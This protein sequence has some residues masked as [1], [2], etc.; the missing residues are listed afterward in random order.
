[1]WFARRNHRRPAYAA[2]R[3]IILAVS[4]LAIV[5]VC[6]A[7]YQYSTGV[8]V[9]Q[10]V[11]A[12]PAVVPEPSPAPPPK[13]N[14]SASSVAVGKMANLGAGKRPVL[15]WYE[16]GSNVA[17]VEAEVDAWEPTGEN[18]DE[19][20]LTKPE[21]RLR[22]PN[23]QF[24]R[25]AADEGWVHLVKRNADALEARS[26]RFSGD[27]T[28]E[29]DRLSA[30]ER[31][32]LPEDERDAPGPDRL[33][34]IMFPDEVT[35]DLE[36]ARVETDGAFSIRM[37]EGELHGVGL[38]VRYNSV[39]RRLE[40]FEISGGGE[41]N[42][43][44]PS[45]FLD[46]AMP[47]SGESD[48]TETDA[49][50]QTAGED[51]AESPAD[52]AQVPPDVDDGIPLFV[53]KDES[54]NV[55]VIQPYLFHVDGHVQMRQLTDGEATSRLSADTIEALFDF[56][57]REREAA[58]L[59]QS[60]LTDSPEE[61][62]ASVE[63]PTGPSERI[64]FQWDGVFTIE[65]TDLPTDAGS[66][67][68]NRLHL[69][70]FGDAVEFVNQQGSVYCQ[71][72]EFE[73]ESDKIRIVG[74]RERPL[75]I[76]SQQCSEL[77]GVEVLIDRSAGMAR[78]TGPARLADDGGATKT[79]GDG[80]GHPSFA[81]GG[82]DVR[83][84]ETTDLILRTKTED[85]VDPVTRNVRRVETEY[86]AEAT[87]IGN[88][89]MKRGDDLIAASMIHAEFDPPTR[90]GAFGERI[91]SL[92]ASG[93]VIMI[94]GGD[95][96]SCE[97]LEAT[98]SPDPSGRMVPRR[99]IAE[100]DVMITQDDRTITARDRLELVMVPI[101]K[102]KPP[103]VL[104]TARREAVARGVDPDSVDWDKFRREYEADVDYTM[105]LQTL[106]ATGEVTAFDPAGGLDLTAE[107]LSCTFTEGRDIAT[108]H[109]VGPDG[110]PAHV[111]WGEFVIN[112]HEIHVD[113]RDERV[114]VPGPGDVRLATR[115]GLDGS[116]SE[117]PQI[118]TIEWSDEMAIRGDS[119]AARFL[120][121]VHATTTRNVS[122]AGSWFDRL[123]KQEPPDTIE[124][125]V[126]DA[127]ELVVEFVDVEPV[128]SADVGV[129]WWV[130]GPL[131]ER[132]AGPAQSPMSGRKF[133]KEPSYVVATRDV[134]GVFANMSPDSGR[135]VNRM[136]LASSKVTV[137]LRAQLVTVPAKGNM[138][139]ED[140]RIPTS[141]PDSSDEVR[142]F[143][144][145]GRTGNMPS[146]TLIMWDDS[147]TYHAERRRADFVG[148]VVLDHRSGGKMQLAGQ[149]VSGAGGESQTTD[150][151]G[152]R[153]RMECKKM[154]IEFGHPGGE[155]ETTGGVG[156]M[157][158]RSVRQFEATGGVYL[159][160]DDIT[161]N[162]F[163]IVKFDQ[164]DLLMIL[165]RNGEDA[166]IFSDL[167]GGPRF[168]GPKFSYNLD[169]GRI[170]ARSSRVSGRQ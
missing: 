114:E 137:D 73:K 93:D 141:S 159:T 118:I 27:V 17:R 58:R 117:E 143:S 146:Q 108:A 49:S 34:H 82:I 9:P 98:F 65:P 15:R 79:G 19:F 25:V 13:P 32:A 36:Q 55:P 40:H 139:I 170:D 121:R 107:S 100:R 89:S 26:G 144:F 30:Q 112:A 161:I 150:V 156:Q 7:V 104:S 57:Q 131:V 86:I 164:S 126:F 106:D 167:S 29:I 16:P 76:K 153:T 22:T 94:R 124:T 72:I 138:L 8:S 33:I 38:N 96:V 68:G 44:A 42:V 122:P 75:L 50:E 101:V 67:L 136:R 28:I 41:L 157:S 169:T 59:G 142:S 125:S 51:V 113:A 109:V 154:L 31:A 45:N 6:F 140:Y 115:R 90:D 103:F 145:A 119:N 74:S 165:G 85:V 129:D 110:T 12:P 35:F 46:T 21:I 130:L 48:A 54:D 123:G 132:L 133:N 53:L 152:R 63:E 168:R 11:D 80:N 127:G 78:I 56:G 128:Q 43:L 147:M 163:R 166:E 88:V 3:S 87:F 102:Q 1:M 155:G 66:A 4:T 37:A 20:H 116:V 64:V 134:V 10:I 83:F 71:R 2:I 84:D 160:D 60:P 39:D 14:E 5:G 148:D 111:E 23:G 47:G 81:A 69:S 61:A 91:K 149:T 99:V 24:I 97:A 77:S 105:G 18:S 158:I 92:H 162:A 70:A 135:V 52:A 95:E 120:G 151:P 62:D